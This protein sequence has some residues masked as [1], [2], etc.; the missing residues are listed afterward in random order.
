MKKITSVSLDDSVC[1]YIDLAVGR[2]AIPSVSALVNDLLAN[3]V[4]KFK[5]T[6]PAGYEFQSMEVKKR[7]KRKQNV[8][9][10]EQK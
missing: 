3:W 4:E 5:A 7:K 6:L 10:T 1:R 9:E 2:K 8:Q